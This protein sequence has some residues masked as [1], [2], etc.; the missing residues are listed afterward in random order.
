MVREFSYR[1]HRLGLDRL[2]EKINE[3][4]DEIAESL[5]LLQQV[6][7]QRP[8]PY[9]HLMQTVYDAKSDEWVN[10][11]SESFPE[12]KTRV[13]QILKEIDPAN[14]SKYQKLTQ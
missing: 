13:V 9:M 1:Y 5:K 8:D 11:F 3:G 12:E 7:R 14:I 10:L 4:R 6:Y 2:A